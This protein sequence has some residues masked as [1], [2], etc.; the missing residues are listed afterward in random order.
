[1]SPGSSGNN[2]GTSTPDRPD[3]GNMANLANSFHSMTSPT[4]DGVSLHSSDSEASRSTA[5]TNR[6]SMLRQGTGTSSPGG[7]RYSYSQR[8]PS[9][10][11][12]S[13][14]SAQTG[15][16]LGSQLPQGL[17]FDH[18]RPAEVGS[19]FKLQAE[20][21]VRDD[22]STL[23]TLRYRQEHAPHLHLGAFLPLPP[24]K[25]SGPLSMSGP[26]P[27]KLIGYIS[28]TSASALTARSLKT[29]QEDEDAW[30]VCLHN[31]CVAPDHRNKR[32]G[33]KL[34]EEFM[35]RLRRA[36]E[37]KGDKNQ[38]KYGYECVALLTHEDDIPF[39]EKLAFKTL[40]VSHVNIG[41]G[42]WFEMRRDIIP[43]DGQPL[44]S[45]SDSKQNDPTSSAKQDENAFEAHT[46]TQEL[47]RRLEIETIERAAEEEPSEKPSRSVNDLV[48]SPQAMSP[49]DASTDSQ[50]EAA[51]PIPNWVSAASLSKEPAQAL[52]QPQPTGTSEHPKSTSSESSDPA[53]F[54]QA[55]ILEALRKQTASSQ[56]SGM[57][58]SRNPGTA[59]ATIMGQTL[60]SKTSVEDAYQALEARLVDRED[61]TNLIDLYCPR[62]ECSC[63]LIKAGN[64]D[65]EMAEIGPLTHVSLTL[66]NSPEP[67][68][69]PVPPPPASLDRIRSAL[70]TEKDVSSGV[71]ARPFWIV[72]SAMIFENI[73]FSKDTDWVPTP[74]RSTRSPSVG[75]EAT[76]NA[77]DNS[78]KRNPLRRTSLFRGPSERRKDKENREK[79]KLDKIQ[80]MS[81]ASDSSQQASTPPAVK[82]K[83]LLC[84][85][86]DCGPLGYTVLPASLEGGNFA[87][88]V[89]KQAQ[90]QEAEAPAQL[91]FV[92]A[93]RVRYRV[94]K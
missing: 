4:A 88:E 7:K 67:P 93:D 39:F 79:D 65:W 1:M 56:G 49:T 55:Q 71:A 76:K 37:G 52:S 29:H 11:S 31:V 91:F 33:L 86:C 81:P 35:K 60:A 45:S 61:Y 58:E 13:A 38:K 57:G 51:P 59:Y 12:N 44:Q 78:E 50:P 2:S 46:P 26:R 74:A 47:S 82:V 53:P 62:E 10:S 77:S 3:T 5:N 24:P 75:E 80:P 15:G 63:L 66:P 89:G 22:R 84:A 18:L 73:G 64:S 36:E 6:N 42:G 40:G 14:S 68:S 94:P 85:D 23:D 8:R 90:G 9:S 27:R 16:R 54:T 43:T 92:A 34:V 28:A 41:S 21:F 32:L 70:G 69:A 19:V 72:H 48:G 20:S 87:R 17:H 25:V 83:Y 30:L